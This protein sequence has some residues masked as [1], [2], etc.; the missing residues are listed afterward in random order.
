MQPTKMMRIAGV[1]V[2]SQRKKLI[3]ALTELG[4][5]QIVKCGERDGTATVAEDSAVDNANIKLARL[6]FSRVFIKEQKA[7]VARLANKGDKYFQFVQTEDCVERIKVKNGKID[8]LTELDAKVSGVD[9]K[10]GKVKPYKAERA[11]LI[12]RKPEISYEDFSTSDEREHPTFKLI[13]TLEKYNQELLKIKAEEV[14]SRIIIE[15][16]APFVKLELKL[17]KYKD[18]KF[19]CVRIGTIKNKKY[20]QLAQELD[21]IPNIVYETQGDATGK[22]T[23]TVT[24]L[25]VCLKE[26]EDMLTEKLEACEFMSYSSTTNQ[27]AKDIVGRE[28]VNLKLCRA[29][30]YDIAATVTYEYDNLQYV[31]DTRLLEDFY[32]V[33][34]QMLQA[35]TQMRSTSTS[36]VFEGWVPDNCI[37]AISDKLDESNLAMSYVVRDPE[38]SEIPPTFIEDNAFVTPYHTVTNMYSSP[39]YNEINPNPFVAFFFILFFGVM[40]SD[41]GY[42]IIITIITSVIL[43]VAR[44]RKNEMSLVKILLGGGISTIFWGIMFGGY[45]GIENFFIKPVLFN[46]IQEPMSMLILS[47]GLGLFQMVVGM[48]INAYSLFKQKK[49]LDAIFGVFSWYVLLIGIAM[50]FIK[51]IPMVAGIA[52]AI[53]GLVGIMI[54]GSL[55]KKGLKTVSGA[56]SKLYGLIGFFSDLMSYTRLFGLGLASSV[57]AMV[58]N[59]LGG[60]VIGINKYIGYI[61]LPIILLIGHTF[62]ILINTLGAYVHNSRLQFVEFFGR[63]Y[64]GGGVLF[65]PLGSN[66]KYYN[67]TREE[68]TKS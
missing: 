46:P 49:P 66:R 59:Q 33:K 52:I 16:V 7:I 44:P 35:E 57:I 25:I 24:V 5:V 56:V 1:G 17:S 41:A 58:F 29:R 14:K 30:R 12:P 3:D 38:E 31:A 65:D 60:I 50:V 15:Q 13:G 47:L 6:A 2:T 10:V 64:T 61:M 22:K 21:L 43:A 40:L 45:F 68:V 39:M 51:Q 18:T 48:G 11:P 42:G 20:Q 27:V 62:N 63:F 8:V 55:H 36:F 23:P 9:I 32:N 19:C 67:F 34:L 37:T 28:I 54:G 53:A 26:C 4:C